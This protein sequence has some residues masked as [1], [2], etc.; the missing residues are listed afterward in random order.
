VRL[1]IQLLSP[2]KW[3]WLTL[4]VGHVTPTLTSALSSTCTPG[5]VNNSNDTCRQKLFGSKK[6]L[7]LQ[8]NLL[9]E[10]LGFILDEEQ[11]RDALMLVDLFHY[12]IRHQEYKKDQPE[13]SPKEDLRAWLR[14]AGNAV[15]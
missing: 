9:F 14:F 13:K 6:E 1:L 2:T 11:Y 7:P 5:H 15:L 3:L 10:E 8:L 4:C 12:F